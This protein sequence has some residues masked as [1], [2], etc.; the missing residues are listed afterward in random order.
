MTLTAIISDDQSFKSDDTLLFKHYKKTFL[1]AV[2]YCC[3]D[4][5]F[6]IYLI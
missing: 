2:K 3:R 5:L 4:T 1:L 6:M